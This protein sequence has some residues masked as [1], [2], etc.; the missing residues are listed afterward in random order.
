MGFF[1]GLESAEYGLVD[2]GRTDGATGYGG[3]AYVS[4]YDYLEEPEK[5]ALVEAYKEHTVE[6]YVKGKR[7]TWLFE[8]YQ[9]YLTNRLFLHDFYPRRLTGEWYLNNTSS[10]PGDPGEILT[11][12]EADNPYYAGNV[13]LSPYERVA[14]GEPR[15]ISGTFE[16]DYENGRIKIL[17]DDGR[18]FFGI[19]EIDESGDMAKLK[20]EY[21]KYRYPDEFSADA[22]V[23]VERT[24]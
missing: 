7:T 17:N 8:P 22:L 19:F 13:V 18:V 3:G 16:V 14:R 9:P 11:I 4:P 1:P 6:R 5:L 24:N 12:I 10:G 15:A 2:L 21:Q 23:Y 20:V